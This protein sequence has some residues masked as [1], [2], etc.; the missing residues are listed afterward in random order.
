MGIELDG[1]PAARVPLDGHPDFA[2]GADAQE[3]LGLVAGHLGGRMAPF[4]AH[5]PRPPP[6]HAALDFRRVDAHGGSIQSAEARC[7]GA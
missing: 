2:V 4:E 3:P 5:V 6:L 1:H 7:E